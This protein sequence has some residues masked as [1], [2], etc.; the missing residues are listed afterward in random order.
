MQELSLTIK[1]FSETHPP[2]DLIGEFVEEIRE[3]AFDL[4]FG[5]YSIETNPFTSPTPSPQESTGYNEG[6][7]MFGLLVH[8]FDGWICE[9]GTEFEVVV[10]SQGTT[11]YTYEGT[12]EVTIST[13]PTTHPSEQTKHAPFRKQEASQSRH[14]RP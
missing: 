6:L 5:R 1:N 7:G 4:E 2:A 10:S 11:V 12:V 3:F 14:T 8:T 13:E 9:Q